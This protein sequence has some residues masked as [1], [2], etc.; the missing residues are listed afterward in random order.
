MARDL[1]NDNN[2]TCVIVFMAGGR[3]NNLLIE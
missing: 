3:D 1:V 2:V